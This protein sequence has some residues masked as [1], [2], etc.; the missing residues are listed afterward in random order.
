MNSGRSI[1]LYS[2]D[3]WLMWNTSIEDIK[4]QIYSHR[5]VSNRQQGE[6]L[7]LPPLGR[8]GPEF[9][10]ARG[11]TRIR[12]PLNVNIK[13]IEFELW[14][15]FLYINFGATFKVFAS[16]SHHKQNIHPPKKIQYGPL[17]FFIK[18][19]GMGSTVTLIPKLTTLAWFLSYTLLRS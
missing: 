9:S 14:K 10:G 19:N 8:A 4:S 17:M 7:E 15:T 6:Y 16:S 5:G 2:S 11:E 3:S 13:L 1:V 18:Q 12:G